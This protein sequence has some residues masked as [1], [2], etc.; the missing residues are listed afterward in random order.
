MLRRAMFNLPI[1]LAGLA[2]YLATWACCTS[3]DGTGCGPPPIP[4]ATLSAVPILP[5]DEQ[6]VLPSPTMINQGAPLSAAAPWFVF[7]TEAGIW[8][9]NPDGSGLTQLTDKPLAST[10]QLTEGL[11]PWGRHLAY[12]TQEDSAAFTL[13]ILALPE[14]VLVA[15]IPMISEVAAGQDPGSV[16]EAVKVISSVA[17]MAWSPDGQLLAFMAAIDGPTLD[18]YVYDVEQEALRRLTDGPSEAVSPSWSPDGRYILHFGLTALGSGAGSDLAGAWAARSDGSEIVSLYE[19]T[20]TG[21][22]SVLGWIDAER[23]L[24]YSWDPSCGEKQLRSLNIRTL[25]VK[26]LWEDYFLHAAMQ[27]LSD[28]LLVAVAENQSACN[29]GQ[30]GGLYLINGE[31]GQAI[32]ILEDDPVRVTWSQEA[33]LY[34]S[35]TE[36]GIQA[37]STLGDWKQLWDLGGNFPIA[38][39][40]PGHLAWYGQEGLW[41]GPLVNEDLESP[42]QVL[43]EPVELAVWTSWDGG[44]LLVF[45]ASGFYTAASPDFVPLLI[46]PGLESRSAG[47]VIL[48]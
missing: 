22:E 12:I 1:V 39:P 38:S 24:L 16:P 5:V 21:E 18:L 29:A 37:I 13:H 45:G 6:D 36:F 9:A 7:A 31:D 30:A 15:E 25:E 10:H 26:M 19:P 34:F 46:A 33:G 27:P 11:A 23:A 48:P 20:E 35:Q 2:L 41:V 3:A 14:G 42:R 43:S 17:V 4:G 32:R 40:L 28:S 8:A 44:R 47:W